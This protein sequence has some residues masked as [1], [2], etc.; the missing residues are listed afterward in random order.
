MCSQGPAASLLERVLALYRQK[1]AYF[2]VALFFGQLL[3][4]RFLL[5]YVADAARYLTPSPD[6]IEE[7]NKIRAEGIRLLR[8]LHESKKYS[9]IIVVGHSLGSVIGYDII[10]HLWVDLRSP[11]APQSL[12]QDQ[13]KAFE[14][15]ARDVN[16]P[17]AGAAVPQDRLRQAQH[18]LWREYRAVGIPWLITDFITLGA[19]LAHGRLLMADNPEAFDL[20]TV[21][22]EYPTCPPVTRDQEIHYKK[23]YQVDVGGTLQPRD[24][25]IPHHGAPFAPTRWVNL[26]FP[27]RRL[28]LGDLI[29]GP[30][31]PLFGNGVRDVPV[32][33]ARPGFLGLG[34]TLACH[35]RYWYKDKDGAA[36]SDC[37]EALGAL[38]SALQLNCLS[39]KQPC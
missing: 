35:T 36:A 2:A 9:R 13:A 37:T 6:N 19:P 24:I 32:C 28:I 12:R 5:G 4:S 11:L 20:R 22:F 17:T 1:Q 31:Q 7:R 25:R 33:L 23:R 30:L 39:A 15:L 21:E 8:T 16:A 38:R 26:Y 29:G 14:Q 18:E 27:Y 34:R 3:A 10:R